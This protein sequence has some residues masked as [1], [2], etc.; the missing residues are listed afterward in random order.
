MTRSSSRPVGVAASMF[1]PMLTNAT[2][3]AFQILI[4]VIR[5]RRFLPNLS[6]RHTHTA[7]IAA[8]RHQPLADR[9]KDDD[10]SRC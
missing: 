2:P 10:P 1:S 4:A 9:A 8:A 7:S 5:W 6:S 3:I